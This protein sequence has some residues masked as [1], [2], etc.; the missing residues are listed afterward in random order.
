MAAAQAYG[1][2]T[3]DNLQALAV[4]KA[5]DAIGAFGMSTLTENKRSMPPMKRTTHVKATRYRRWKQPSLP[6]A[7]GLGRKMTHHFSGIL[8][9]PIN[10]TMPTPRH[11]PQPISPTMSA[12]CSIWMRG[13]PRDRKR[14]INPISKTAR[15]AN[16]LRVCMRPPRGSIQARSYIVTGRSRRPKGTESTGS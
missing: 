7:S 10:P 8:R 5:L 13:W 15:P 11:A 3:A 2:G 12:P 6:P 1:C 14:N 9:R 16:R 4:I